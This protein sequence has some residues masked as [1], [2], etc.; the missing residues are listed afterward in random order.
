M[1]GISKKKGRAVL[2]VV[3]IRSFSRGHEAHV[4]LRRYCAFKQSLAIKHGDEAS[5]KL[6]PKSRRLVGPTVEA[7]AV[8]SEVCER[9][10]LGPRSQSKGHCTPPQN[11]V[12]AAA[13]F[14]PFLIES[15]LPL[16]VSSWI[17]SSA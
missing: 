14:V 1:D 8:V 6:P 17:R 13:K 12:A 15:L 11:P 5:D 10:R 16:S 2:A 9:I 4:E 3:L 7:D